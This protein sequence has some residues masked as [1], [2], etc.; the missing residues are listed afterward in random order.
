LTRQLEV[1]RTLDITGDFSVPGDFI[2][3]KSSVTIKAIARDTEG[4]VL[5][6]ADMIQIK[7]EAKKRFTSLSGSVFVA[8]AANNKIKVLIP[9]EEGRYNIELDSSDT[10]FVGDA[11]MQALYV[12]NDGKIHKSVLTTLLFKEGFVEPD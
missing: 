10:D 3:K 5:D 6:L 2:V 11:K 4:S 1:K 7:V 8:T 12:M 9:T